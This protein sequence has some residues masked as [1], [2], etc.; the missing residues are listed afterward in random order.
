L[1]ADE[2]LQIVGFDSK[3]S[4]ECDSSL[5]QFLQPGNYFLLANTFDT[6]VNTECGISGDYRINAALSSNGINPLGLNTSLNGTPVNAS[7]SGGI[8]SDD[9]VSFGNQFSS[10]DSLD[11][12]ART[13]IDPEHVGE[14]GFLVIAAFTDEQILFVNEQGEFVDSAAIPEVFIPAS[15]KILTAV[16]EF[17]AFE[18]LVPASLGISEIQVDF[19]F[20]YGLHSNPDE[21]YFHQAPLHLTVTP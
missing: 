4:S 20:G 7:F 8:S 1:I 12:S 6:Q 9:G 16:E 21:L 3:S 17:I 5:T 11:I 19:F 15:N 10:N 18:N 13:D 2:N 14:A